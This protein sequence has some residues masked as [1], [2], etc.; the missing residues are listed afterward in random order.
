MKLFKQYFEL[1]VWVTAITFL[2]VAPSSAVPH[3]SWC[4]FK[5]IGINFCPGCGLGHSINYLFHGN[6]QAS[7]SSHP[8]GLFAVIII[9]Y[10]IYRLLQL[11]IFSGTIK[12]NYN[13]RQY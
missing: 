12:N 8:L 11:H 10:R 13:V 6:L 4:L 2:A 9:I 1:I 5:I 3:Y 7:L